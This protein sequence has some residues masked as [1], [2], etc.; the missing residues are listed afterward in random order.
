[1][2]LENLRKFEQSEQLLIETLD[3]IKETFGENH[4][5]TMK[6]RYRLARCKFL[7]GKF[8]EAA[9]LLECSRLGLREMEQPSAYWERYWTAEIDEG[10]RILEIIMQEEHAPSSRS[11]SSSQCSYPPDTSNMN[12]FHDNGSTSPQTGYPPSRTAYFL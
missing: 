8:A 7:G 12:F 4:D 11:A 1:M 9:P 2:V 10:E 3:G 5:S 6:A